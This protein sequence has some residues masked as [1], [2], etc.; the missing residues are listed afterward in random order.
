VTTAAVR[1]WQRLPPPENPEENRETA[2]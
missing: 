1:W 2:E